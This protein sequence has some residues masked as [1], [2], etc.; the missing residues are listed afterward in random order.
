MTT[1]Q[2]ACERCCIYAAFKSTGIGSEDVCSICMLCGVPTVSLTLQLP[3]IS[4]SV[5]EDAPVR[6]TVYNSLGEQVAELVN[7]S[8]VAGSYTV[9][10]DASALSSGVY[11]YRLTAG[12]ETLTKHMTLSK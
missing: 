4:F 1:T 5:A 10:F 6:L 11:M 2:L 3:S 8:L 12:T 7:E 9:Q